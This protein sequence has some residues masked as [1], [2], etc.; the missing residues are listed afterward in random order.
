MLCFA[1]GGGGRTGNLVER[2]SGSKWLAMSAPIPKGAFG[3][4][5]RIACASNSACTSIGGY[6]TNSSPSVNFADRWNGSAWEVQSMANPS[7]QTY[8]W[9]VACPTAITCTAVGDV[10]TKAYPLGQDLAERWT[11]TSWMIEPTPNP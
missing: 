1:V 2:W 4:L 8:L 3:S 10:E 7:A 6:A 9:D 5:E 11:G